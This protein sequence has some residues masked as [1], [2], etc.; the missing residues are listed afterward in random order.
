M[1][2]FHL[3]FRVESFSSARVKRKPGSW[4]LIPDVLSRIQ[5][6][7]SSL[8]SRPIC[9]AQTTPYNSKLEP[10]THYFCSKLPGFCLGFISTPTYTKASRLAAWVWGTFFFWGVFYV[11]CFMKLFIKKNLEMISLYVYS[12]KVH[13]PHFQT[14]VVFSQTDGIP[15]SLRLPSLHLPTIMMSAFL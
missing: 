9:S 14:A 1:L 6:W 11:S 7:C 2:S 12:P 4:F 8:S 10:A 3:L 5:S 13:H 15:I